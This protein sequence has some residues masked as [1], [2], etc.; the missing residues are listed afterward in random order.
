MHRDWLK[1]YFQL[2][3]GIPTHD[4][5]LRVFSAVNASEFQQC[6]FEWI[7]TLI[8]LL[9]ENV[10]PIDG[11]SIRASRRDK[12]NLRAL[13]IV[14]AFSCA[15]G[16]SLGQMIVD[17]KT[18]EIT[19]IP[20]LLKKLCI[21]GA[22]VTLDA[23]GCQKEIALQI[24]GQQGDY[25]LR[26]KENQGGLLE[27]IECTFKEAQKADYKNRVHYTAHDETNN[28]HGRIENRKCIVLPLMYLMM[29][30]LKW[31][32]LQSLVNY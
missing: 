7:K 5:F 14:S 25:I 24:I 10:I 2:P 32:G 26:V 17:K 31:K 30:K 6:F 8:E 23:M 21:A 1:N 11:K 3:N 12:G 29:M 27:T 18:N 20:D 22:I 9:P 4:T 19:V 16:I 15:N 13:H 28:D